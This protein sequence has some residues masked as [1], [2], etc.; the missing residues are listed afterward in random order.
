M[1]EPKTVEVVNFPTPAALSKFSIRTTD[2]HDDFPLDNDAY[3]S[4]PEAESVPL[5][6]ISNSVSKNL[7]TA[8][9]VI[10]NIRTE[11]G[12][13]P[14]VPD[15]SHQIIMISN[16]NRDLILPGTMKSIRKNVDDGA[17]LIV[18]AQPD[19]LAIDFEGMLPVERAENSGPAMIE[20]NRYV[21]ATQDNTLTEDMNFGRVTKYLKVKPFSGATTIAATDNNVSMITMK[22]YGKGMVVYFGMMDEQSTFKEDIYYPV[23]WKRLFDMAI[24]KQDLTELNFRTGKLINLLVKQKIATPFGK[25]E[26]ETI[27]LSHQGIYMGEEKNFVANLANE[28]ESNINGEELDKKLGILSDADKTR[29]NVKFEL[30][31]YFI[32]GLLAAVFLE[33]LWIKFRGDL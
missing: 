24:K 5:L 26:A 10:P 15:I 9:E 8:L 1:L 20:E 14:K 32:I 25:V 6:I 30:T 18:V 11:R 12:T 4:T 22:S 16:V 27:F 21:M 3:I 7:A 31:H 19:V 2:G 33:L 23:F 13:P 17:A 29:E 28:E